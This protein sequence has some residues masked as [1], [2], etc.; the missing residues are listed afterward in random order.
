V[1]EWK[2]KKTN[3]LR[4][5][6]VVQDEGTFDDSLFAGV[7]EELVAVSALQEHFVKIVEAKVVGVVEKTVTKKPVVWEPTEKKT[8]E[9]RRQQVAIQM[10]AWNIDAAERFLERL[11]SCE[12]LEIRNDLDF[13]EDRFHQLVQLIADM[14]VSGGPDGQKVG[15]IEW[16]RIGEIG[17]EEQYEWDRNVEGFLRRL[18]NVHNF[19]DRIESLALQMHVEQEL[20]AIISCAGNL[21]QGMDCVLRAKVVCTIF[22]KI[23]SI[24]NRLNAGDARLNRADGFDVIQLLEASDFLQSY[25]GAEGW[26]LLR[27]LQSAELTDQDFESLE[28]LSQAL[29]HITWRPSKEKEDEGI[30]PTDLGA[31]RKRAGDIARALGQVEQWL[32]S[33]QQLLGAVPGRATTDAVRQLEEFTALIALNRQ[34]NMKVETD[35]DTTEKTLTKF[36]RFLAH[37]PPKKKEL[38]V[39]RSL[40][41]VAFFVRK[42]VEN[43]KSTTRRAH[44]RLNTAPHAA[45]K[46]AAQ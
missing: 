39:G 43:W 8:P 23:L 1:L 27:H 42:L 36:H 29:Q 15:G 37:Q 19:R 30:D 40:G 38:V 21:Q 32:D 41:M 6:R 35:L 10:K 46:M 4:W 7:D 13:R 3:P 24:G 16:T 9:Q 2:D 22:R 28:Q 17:A 11:H 18:Q 12:L 25:K 31:L 26:S 14:N 33:E 44:R 5:K 45:S 20:D 34:R